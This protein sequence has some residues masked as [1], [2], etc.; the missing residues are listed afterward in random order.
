MAKLSSVLARSYDYSDAE[1]KALEAVKV[2][3]K[4]DGIVIAFPIRE[5]NGASRWGHIILT[6]KQVSLG[7]GSDHAVLAII[8]GSHQLLA[9]Y[10]KRLAEYGIE[11]SEIVERTTKE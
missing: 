5:K 4:E 9:D 3:V 11:E 7:Q 10:V 1:R 8:Q 6:R 2:V